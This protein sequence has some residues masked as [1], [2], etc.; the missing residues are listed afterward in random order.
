[1]VTRTQYG[2]IIIYIWSE[3]GLEKATIE[4]VPCY[5][6]EV[7]LV[8]GV[9]QRKLLALEIDLE[10]QLECPDYKKSQTSK[11]KQNINFRYNSKKKIEVVWTSP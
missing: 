10:D 4:L 2:G 8:D 11:F 6:C 5:G 3:K 9:E 1:M 7:W